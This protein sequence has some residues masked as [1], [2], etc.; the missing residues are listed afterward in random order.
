MLRDMNDLGNNHIRNCL[1]RHRRARGFTQQDVAAILGLKSANM[2]SRWENGSCLPSTTNLLK[3]AAIYRTMVDA[4]YIDLLR[5]LK[6]DLLERERS[7]LPHD[8]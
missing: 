1:R 3:L 8:D 6:T 7:V 5:A 4:L 2:I